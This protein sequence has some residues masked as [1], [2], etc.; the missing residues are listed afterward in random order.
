MGDFGLALGVMGCFTLIQTAYFFDCFCW[1][2]LVPFLNA[3]IM[4]FSAMWDF[5]AYKWNCISL[6]MGS[7][8]NISTNMI[9]HLV[10]WCNGGLGK[11]P[12]LI[13][14]G[15]DAFAVLSSQYFGSP[16]RC[17]GQGDV[18]SGRY[19]VTLNHLYL[20]FECFVTNKNFISRYYMM[21]CQSILFTEFLG[22]L[23]IQH[24]SF[25]GMGTRVFFRGWKWQ[26]RCSGRKVKP[27]KHFPAL[28]SSV[29]LSFIACLVDEW[30]SECASSL[31]NTGW[32]MNF[33]NHLNFG[34]G[35]LCLP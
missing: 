3:I 6:F 32:L 4:S 22:W 10:T 14:W 17:G 18:L 33:G 23:W 29:E 16:R 9:A 8:G 30:M 19:K 27:Q 35:L 31:V 25:C 12:E 5:M 20:Y 28:L 21:F 34:F 2:S 1:C 26:Q 13:C 15:W 24:C 11:F 7:V